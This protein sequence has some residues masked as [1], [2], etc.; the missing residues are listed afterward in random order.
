[1]PPSC[2]SWP[3][4]GAAVGAPDLVTT[5]PAEFAV[6]DGEDVTLINTSDP[7]DERRT[8]LAVVSNPTGGGKADVVVAGVAFDSAGNEAAKA[9]AQVIAPLDDPE[10]GHRAGPGHVL[11]AVAG[12]VHSGVGDPQGRA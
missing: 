11:R 12:P 4:A 1:M 3:R 6:G 9:R 5:G 8:L 10:G 2:S 7:L